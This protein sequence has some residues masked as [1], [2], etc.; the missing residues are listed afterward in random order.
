MGLYISLP[1]RYEPYEGTAPLK[2]GSERNAR[3][4]FPLIIDKVSNACCQSS[5]NQPEG[6]RVDAQPVSVAVY[7]GHVG[8]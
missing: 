4:S 2:T 7:P 3:G 1:A 8:E 5:V 6:A